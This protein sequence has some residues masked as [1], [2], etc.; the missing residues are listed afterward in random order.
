MG[1]INTKGKWI[2]PAGKYSFISDFHDGLAVFSEKGI[3]KY[4]TDEM[5]VEVMDEG[6]Y[7]FLDKTGKVAIQEKYLKLSHFNNGFARF[8][9]GNKWGCID[10]T[11]NEIIAADYDF[12]GRFVAT[13]IL[14]R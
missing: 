12:I 14:N 1:L 7:G 4:G 13:P 5:P 10:K 6:L 8:Y 9:N 3:A 2:V 11:G